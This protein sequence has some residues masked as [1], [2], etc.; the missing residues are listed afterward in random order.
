MQVDSRKHGRNHH[1][2][3]INWIWLLVLHLMIGVVGLGVVVRNLGDGSRSYANAW[4]SWSSLPLNFCIILLSLHWARDL[5]FYKFI[6]EGENKLLF[7]EVTPASSSLTDYRAVTTRKRT[8]YNKYYYNNK[9]N[10]GN[11]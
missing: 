1:Q 11:S 5:G 10:W 3:S 8:C 9:N 2:R 4:A 6:V 7:Q